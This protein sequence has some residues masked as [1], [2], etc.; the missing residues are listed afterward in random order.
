MSGL[1]RALGPVVLVAA[2]MSGVAAGAEAVHP[3]YASERAVA[4]GSALLQTAATLEEDRD[5]RAAM[6]M[7]R[8]CAAVALRLD[9]AAD[10][11]MAEAREF[12][13]FYHRVPETFRPLFH[14]AVAR[15]RDRRAGRSGPHE[16]LALLAEL[17]PAADLAA[18]P[19]EMT[20]DRCAAL[21]TWLAEGGLIPRAA[22]GG[23]QAFLQGISAHCPL[24]FAAD[25]CY[26][27]WHVH[28]GCVCYYAAKADW[29][30]TVDP[31]GK[32]Y[33]AE[34][35]ARFEGT[36]FEGAFAP[37]A[38]CHLYYLSPVIVNGFLH[39]AYDDPADDL[40][41]RFSYW[42]EYDGRL[43]DA[44]VYT[45]LY[46]FNEEHDAKLALTAQVKEKAR[47]EMEFWNRT[48]KP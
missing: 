43:F 1:S 17:F 40:F 42:R 13:A 28:R 12:A 10:G 15:F 24:L 14:P 2:L 11:D 25:E 39:P 37:T 46:Q 21:R 32:P 27:P 35:G 4:L 18:G 7:A 33:T 8:T 22:P 9:R 31:H 5:G 34:R 16:A 3:L 30:E 36:M 41:R 47:V 44:W 6:E 45:R 19:P 20:R 38:V 23:F 26:R 48:Y 29:R